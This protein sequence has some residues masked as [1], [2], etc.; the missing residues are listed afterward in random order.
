MVTIY[1]VAEL[2][3]VSLATVSRVMNGGTKVR[4][5]THK[6][7]TEAVATLKYRPNAMARSLALNC[8]N[9]V[10]VLISEFHGPIYGEMM[11]GIEERLR[12]FG[13]HVIITAGHSD[14]QTEK[15]GIEFLLSRNCDALILHVDAVSDEYLLELSKLTTPFVL[16]NRVLPALQDKCFSLDNHQGGYIATKSL[17]EKGHKEIAYISG[18]L[19]RT[20][21]KNRY[22]GHQKAMAEFGLGCNED[23]LYEGDFREQ[24]GSAGMSKLLQ[25]TIFFQPLYVPTMKPLQGLCMQREVRD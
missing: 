2:A 3:G 10:G 23:L 20:D 21:A 17:L 1:Q 6:K 25:K 22:E 19:W 14:E 13:K 9:S 5:K 18:P 8:S 11:S 15:D 7:V 16:I 24:G 12:T 4:E